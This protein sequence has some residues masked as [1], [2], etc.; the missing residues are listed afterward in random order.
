MARIP[1]FALGVA[2]LVISSS[3]GAQGTYPEK[4][5]RIIVGFPPGGPADTVARLLGQ[6]LGEALGQPIIVDNV[7]GAAG[8]I[9]TARLAN[10]APDGH[11]LALV[12]EAQILINPSLYRLPYDPAKDFQ[13]VSQVTVSPYLLLVPNALPAKSIQ[14]LVS[15]ALAQ[16]SVLTFASAGSG[17]A[18]HM[19]AELFKS[20]AGI[21]IRHIPYKGLSPAIPDLLAGRVTMMFSPMATALPLVRDGKLRALAVTSLKGSPT[22]PQLPS[23]AESGYPGFEVTGWLGLVAPSKTPPAITRKLHAETAKALALSDLRSTLAG[24]GME[25]IGNSPSVFAE[26]INSE[27]PKWT[28]VIRESGIR[29]D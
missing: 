26:I 11:T 10:V 5:V 20:V 7:P 29:V 14:E 19:A 4:P 18:P 22:V 12:T 25:A 16:P 2:A 15:L 6:K 3:P 9:A 28:K 8:N 24:L 1:C 13:P 17:S 23:V 21:D 27:L